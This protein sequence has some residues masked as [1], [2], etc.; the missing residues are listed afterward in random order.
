[1]SVKWKDATSYSQGQRGKIG[2]NSWEAEISGY[3]I[4][5]SSGHLY[6]PDEWIMNCRGLDIERK[7]LG[8]KS[9][10]SEND[11]QVKAVDYAV[12]VA[13]KNIQ[14]LT[15]FVHEAVF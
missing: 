9:T 4:W 10:M 14:K 6:Y 13:G 15:G 8:P 12:I 7:V 5:I 2:P 3:K 1:M 11:A